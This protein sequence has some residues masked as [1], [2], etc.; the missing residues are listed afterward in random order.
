MPA[1]DHQEG[2][3][4]MDEENQLAPPNLVDRGGRSQAA[5]TSSC[6]HLAPEQGVEPEAGRTLKG[7]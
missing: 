1:H 2:L 5:K 7:S 6:Y 4:G 3:S